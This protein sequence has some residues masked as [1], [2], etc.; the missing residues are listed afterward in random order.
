MVKDQGYT[1]VEPYLDKVIDLAFQ[2]EIKKGK[3]SYLGISNF[4]TD[5]KGQYN[6]NSLNGLPNS[7]P[8][9]VVEFI[10]SVPALT[11]QPIKVILE[12]SE[13]AKN[14][15]GYFGVDT[16]I[17]KNDAGELKVNPCLEINVR[18]NM[19]LLCLTLER[20]IVPHKKGIYR[21]WFQP[22]TFFKDL[23]KEMETKHP[24]VL[25]GN[26]IAS[27]F[28]PLTEAKEDTMFGAYILV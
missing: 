6:G 18:Y 9:N 27:G 5:Y 22:G 10:E 1:I 4:S 2:F 19:G 11:L 26:K 14:Y 25:E 15:E 20:F 23:K 7:L 21:T 8:R 24:L 17:F 28:F 3:V 13:M 16:L 12:A